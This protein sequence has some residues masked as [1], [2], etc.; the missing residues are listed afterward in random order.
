MIPRQL[1]PDIGLQHVRAG[2]TLSHFG[3]KLGLPA[4]HS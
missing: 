3:A 2:S 1:V 4:E